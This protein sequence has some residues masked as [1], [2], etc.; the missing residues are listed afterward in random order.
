VAHPNEA[1]LRE[2]FEVLGR[3]DLDTLLSQYWAEDMR[4]HVSGRSPLAGDGEGAAQFL[5]WLGRVFELSGGT[6]SFELQDVLANDQQAVVLGTQRAER[7]GKHWEDNALGVYHIRDGKIAEF[8][9]YL[10]DQ[11]AADEFW[12]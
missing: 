6:W 3:G 12:S 11:Y 4:W 10:G 8:W 7:E 5:E 9:N 2:G 1:F